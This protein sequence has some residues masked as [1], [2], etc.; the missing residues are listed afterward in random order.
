MTVLT[1]S[2]FCRYLWP[3]NLRKAHLFKIDE[4]KRFFGPDTWKMIKPL[5]RDV[6]PALWSI[7]RFLHSTLRHKKRLPSRVQ[8]GHFYT[9]LFCFLLAEIVDHGGLPFRVFFSRLRLNEAFE[10]CMADFPAF[11]DYLRWC[12]FHGTV[13]I[14]S[15]DDLRIYPHNPFK[16]LVR[17]PKFMTFDRRFVN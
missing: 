4:I 12:T 2:F 9:R 7:L 11:K 3:L 5:H 13:A 8:Q 14:L 10:R 15:C 16:Q 1:F 17:Y 6:S